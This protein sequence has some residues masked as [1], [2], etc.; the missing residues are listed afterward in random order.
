QR[1]D[2]RDRADV[3]GRRAHRAADRVALQVPGEVLAEVGEALLTAVPV[4]H[5]PDVPAD[6]VDHLAQLRCRG[7]RLAGE[8]GGQ[9]PE[10][11]G[12]AEAPAPDDDTVAAGRG[13]HVER[14]LAG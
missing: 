8:R 7:H 5:Q 9:V 12:P 4:D 13:D 14:V 6:R 3:A 10:D 2:V 1:L 11:P